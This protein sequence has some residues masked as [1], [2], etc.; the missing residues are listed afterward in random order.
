MNAAAYSLVL[1]AFVGAVL[2]ACV[3]AVVVVNLPRYRLKAA[4]R[5]LDAARQ[6]IDVALA[7]L[8]AAEKEAYRLGYRES[9]PEGF[10][11]DDRYQQSE[12]EPGVEFGDEPRKGWYP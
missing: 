10:G 6:P 1:L 7:E 8:V 2:T 9:G 11:R 3:G 5:R 12:V 4:V